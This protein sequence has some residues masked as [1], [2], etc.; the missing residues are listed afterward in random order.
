MTSHEHGTNAPPLWR[1]HNYVLLQGG[2]LV[3]YVGN[4]QQ[5][6]ALPLLVLER[7]A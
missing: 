1:N 3:S 7:I 5:S 2:Q 4:Q 6:I